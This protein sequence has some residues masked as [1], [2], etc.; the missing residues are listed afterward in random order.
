MSFALKIDDLL[1]FFFHENFTF[2]FEKKYNEYD[3]LDNR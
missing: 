2:R 3:W 1:V